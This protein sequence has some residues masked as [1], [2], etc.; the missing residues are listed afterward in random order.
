[1]DSENKI[2]ESE[3]VIDFNEGI[4]RLGKK[5]RFFHI[6]KTF[7]GNGRFAEL[8]KCLAE[9]DTEGAKSVLHALKGTAANLSLI[10]V[11]KSAEILEAQ[12]KN[13]VIDENELEKLRVNIENAEKEIAR[14]DNF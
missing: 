7:D 4:S 14:I 12:V 11:R 8:K 6:L 9:K 1:M 10:Q 13:G 5:E 2:K 3:Y